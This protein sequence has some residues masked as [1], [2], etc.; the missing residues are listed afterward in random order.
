MR[1]LRIAIRTLMRRPS[2]AAITVLALTLGLGG[3][4]AIYTPVDEVVLD[5]LPYPE[6]ERLVAVDHPAPTWGERHWGLSE[7]GWFAFL[8]SNRTLDGLAVY[9]RGDAVLGGM[10]RGRTGAA[11]R[12]EHQPVGRP[13]HRARRGATPAA[14]GPGVG[15]GRGCAEPQLLAAPFRWR[16]RCGGPALELEGYPLDV[17]GIVEPGV[18]LEAAESD[19]RRILATFEETLP[20]AYWSGFIEGAGL[21]GAPRNMT[22]VV[23]THGVPPTS[24][25]GSVWGWPCRRHGMAGP[26]VRGVRV[27]GASRWGL[28]RP[29]RHPPTSSTCQPPRRI[30]ARGRDLPWAREKVR[31]RGD[32][33][34][35]D[36]GWGVRGETT[37]RAP[38]A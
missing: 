10:G 24:V 38:G 8:D 14:G 19:L 22:L 2:F 6:P 21:W 17:V 12:G 3:T 32:H 15:C 4:A 5:P 28:A 34:A 31:Y 18:A 20:E 30:R 9:E 35:T 36:P 23:R 26:R 29:A 25:A 11:G 16:H 7:A 33:A 37:P 13:G 1:A 27:V